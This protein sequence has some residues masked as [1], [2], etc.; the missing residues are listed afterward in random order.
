MTDAV[1]KWSPGA[2]YGPVLSQTDLYLLNVDLELHPILADT[3][4][5]FQFMFNLSTGQTGGFNHGSDAEQPFTARD[6]PATLPRVED[7]II[8]TESSPW[9]TIVRNPA[10]VTLGDVCTTLWKDYADNAV[11][12]KEFE[13][14]PPRMQDQVRRFASGGGASNGWSQYY[15]PQTPTP[16][17]FRRTDWL[18]ERVY[19]NKLMR[20]DSYSRQRLGYAAPNIFTMQLRAY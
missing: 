16:N 8:I 13:S 3:S 19:F 1:G 9:C 20:V 5:S 15:S 11:T 12:D 18:R 17:R 10:G 4:D 6:E 14:L 7:L 2:S